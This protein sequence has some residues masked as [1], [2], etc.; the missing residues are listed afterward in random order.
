MCSLPSAALGTRKVFLARDQAAMLT[1]LVECVTDC[2]TRDDGYGL[3]RHRQVFERFRGGNKN[4]HLLDAILMAN[5][6]L[7]R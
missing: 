1:E 2:E 5:H 6:L 4:T 3:K 7:Q